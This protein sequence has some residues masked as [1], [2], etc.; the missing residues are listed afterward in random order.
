MGT[1]FGTRLRRLEESAPAC[2]G[3][4]PQVIRIFEEVVDNAPDAAAVDPAPADPWRGHREN[5]RCPRCGKPVPVVLVVYG[6]TE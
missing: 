2:R 6:G 3:C 1:R 4:G 5:A